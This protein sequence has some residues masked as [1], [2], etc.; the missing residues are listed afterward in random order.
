MLKLSEN[1]AAALETIRR[2]EEI[3]ESHDTRLTAER[4]SPGGIAVRLE[5]VETAGEEDEV[6]E[7]SGTEVYVDPVIAEPLA[8]SVMDVEDSPE[9]LS[10]V[11]RPQGGM[12]GAG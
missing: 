12:T 10:F 4:Q 11:F 6:T 5:F 1:A 3:P 9:G 8:E 7:Q 2:S